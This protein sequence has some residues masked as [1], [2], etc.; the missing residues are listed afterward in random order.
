MLFTVMPSMCGLCFICFIL[1][2]IRLW[3]DVPQYDEAR[4]RAVL[5][6]AM[7][8]EYIEVAILNNMLIYSQ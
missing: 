1:K 4:K 7:F 3:R 5:R 8:S 2:T 6:F